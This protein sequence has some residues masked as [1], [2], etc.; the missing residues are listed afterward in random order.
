MLQAQFPEV[1]NQ[2]GYMTIFSY[3]SLYCTTCT[4]GDGLLGLTLFLN[5]FGL[6]A[7]PR[8]KLP[9][10]ASDKVHIVSMNGNLRI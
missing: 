9:V 1:P 2:E 10:S 7:T 8:P 6:L 3:V 4:Y 5:H